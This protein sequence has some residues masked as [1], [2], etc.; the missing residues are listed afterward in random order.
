[1]INERNAVSLKKLSLLCLSALIGAPSAFATNGDLLIGLGAKTRAMGGAGIAYSHGSQSTLDNPALI[2]TVPCKEA[3]IS[4]TFFYPDIKTKATPLM[5][6]YATSDSDFFV[7]PSLSVAKPLGEHWFVGAGMWGTAGLGTDFEG[8][9]SLFNMKTQLMLMQMSIPIAYRTGGWSFGFAPIVEYGSL[10]IEYGIPHLIQRRSDTSDDFGFGASVGMTYHFDNGLIIGAVYKTLINMT[11][12]GVLS[13][14]TN[15][16]MR[17]DLEQPGEYGVGID[18][19]HERHTI[20][21]DLK[22]ILWGSVDGYE[23]FNWQ[24][25]D[26]FA[27]GYEYATPKW[28]IRC[29]YNHAETPIETYSGTQTIG[30]IVNLLNLLGFPATSEDHYTVG[31]S[32][33]LDGRSSFDLAF[34][35]S[36]EEHTEAGLSGIGFGKIINEHREMSFT[37]QYNYAY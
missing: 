35:Y 36:P 37:I 24:D 11:Y 15:G 1:L 4:A 14:A 5:R 28:A 31:A 20:A 22:R 12:E 3:S 6:D 7:I 2:A 27:I 13:G 18:Y 19:T 34:V 16:A 8:S 9:H 32:Y 29:G 30:A 21:I 23:D 17:D 10:D 26:V 33:V 25:Q